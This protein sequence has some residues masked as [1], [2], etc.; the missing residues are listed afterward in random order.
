[1]GWFNN[2]VKKTVFDIWGSN[3]FDCKDILIFEDI[4]THEEAVDKLLFV[5]KQ[6]KEN[7]CI[8]NPNGRLVNCAFI[9]DCIIEE[10]E[11]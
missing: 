3:C 11:I 4:K 8:I 9:S 1:M 2:K 7:N 10:N 5:A 6:I